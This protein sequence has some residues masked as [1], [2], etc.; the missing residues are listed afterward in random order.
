[1]GEGKPKEKMSVG[2]LGESRLSERKMLYFYYTFISNQLV[3]FLLVP[4][5]YGMDCVENG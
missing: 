4:I 5:K 2:V 1:M 3:Q